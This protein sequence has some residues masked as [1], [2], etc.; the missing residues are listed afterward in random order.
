MS[1]NFNVNTPQQNK[2]DQS[3]QQQQ[4]KPAF[5]FGSGFGQAASTQS[6]DQSSAKPQFLFGGA[7]STPA[8]GGAQP[9]NQPSFSFGGFGSTPTPAGA[10][11]SNTTATATAATQKPTFGFGQSFGTPSDKQTPQVTPF[12]TPAAASTSAQPQQNAGAAKPAFS[13]GGGLSAATQPKSDQQQQQQKPAAAFG[14]F[15]A[16]TT[17]GVKTSQAP[18]FGQTL[19]GSATGDK[20]Q[21]ASKPQF[22]FGAQSTTAAAPTSTPKPA[23]EKKG[24]TPAF[25]F[26]AG[27]AAAGTP[28]KPPADSGDMS[29]DSSQPPK[30]MMGGPAQEEKV[31]SADVL[32]ALKGKTISEILSE[33]QRTLYESS[34]T[35]HQ[36]AQEISQLDAQLVNVTNQISKVVMESEQSNQKQQELIQGLDFIETQQNALDKEL[37]RFEE[38]LVQLVE[39]TSQHQGS[40]VQ[41]R[42][43]QFKLP[44]GHIVNADTAREKTYTTAE[45]LSQ[46]LFVINQQIEDAVSMLNKVYASGSGTSED[47]TGSGQDVIGVVTKVLNKHYNSLQWIDATVGQLNDKLSKLKKINDGTKLL[48]SK[49]DSRDR[50]FSP[51][52]SSVSKQYSA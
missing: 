45:N 31:A 40:A 4:Q 11:S 38:K 37:D 41:G 35:F 5:S 9:Q 18:L 46:D 30:L 49:D 47:D 7:S 8:Q 24:P 15:G 6:A 16:T 25:S 1:F 44:N 21:D 10:P 22:S 28:A 14:G 42:V 34:K 36:R 13:F 19:G 33:W 51:R 23:E 3:Q 20:K 17:E 52:S 27:N 32:T 2:S 12:G 26:G 50:Q 48:Q 43:A 39:K 29:K